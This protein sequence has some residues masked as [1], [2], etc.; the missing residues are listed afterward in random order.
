M[1]FSN[2]TPYLQVKKE[3]TYHK[4][5]KKYYMHGASCN[6][7]FIL[8]AKRMYFKRLRTAYMNNGRE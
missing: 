1:F 3:V 5:N 6:A 8:F 2:V 7:D 4:E